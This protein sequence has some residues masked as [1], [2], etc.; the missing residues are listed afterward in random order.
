[1]AGGWYKDGAIQEQIDASVDDAVAKARGNIN[2]GPSLS[3]CEHCGEKIPVLRQ[4][5]IAGVR[6][7]VVCQAEQDK[8]SQGQSAY[9]RRA[10]KDSQLR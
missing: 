1:M 4:K 6:L 8:Q 5:A 10:S 2:K 9:N 7:C 3:H